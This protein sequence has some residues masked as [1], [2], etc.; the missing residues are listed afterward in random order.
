VA[1]SVIVWDIE[2]VPDLKGFAAA[3]GYVGNSDVKFEPSWAT[4]SPSTSTTPSFA[5]GRL[6]RTAKK[7]ATGS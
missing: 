1:T 7:A 2:T 6:W 3:N 4:S 5:L